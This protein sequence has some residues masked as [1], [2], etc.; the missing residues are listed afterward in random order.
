MI[1]DDEDV[2]F[3]TKD[4][5]SEA[6]HKKDLL[7]AWI[8]TVARIRHLHAINSVSISDG[9]DKEYCL[10]TLVNISSSKLKSYL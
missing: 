4:I 6:F 10:V 1:V 9:K 2:F 5:A 7:L 3:D 8:G